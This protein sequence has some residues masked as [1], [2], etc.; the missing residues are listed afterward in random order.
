MIIFLVQ[1][2]IS[3]IWPQQY[4]QNVNPHTL[5]NLP[6][7]QFLPSLTNSLNILV[8][9]VDSNGRN[10]QRFV[11]TRS[12][13]MMLVSIDP[14]KSQVAVIS[15]PRDSRVSIANGHGTDK[16]NAAHALGGPQLAMETVRQTLNV[17]VD[18]YLVMDEEGFR[19]FLEEL[20]PI[21]VLIEKKMN[22]ADHSAALAI[23]LEPGLKSLDARQAEGYIRFR[24]DARG[25]IGR[26]ERQQWFARQIA[27]KFA[28]PQ[29]IIKLPQLL[30]IAS[31][32][33]ITDLSVDEMVKLVG[34]ACHL[35]PQRIEMATLPGKPA[36]IHGISYWLP[37][38]EAAAPLLSK[39]V[40]KDPRP[41]QESDFNMAGGG[42]ALA[43]TPTPLETSVSDSYT[44]IIRYPKGCEKAADDL[45]ILVKQ[46]GLVSKGKYKA[47]LSDCQHE[48]IVE[49]SV[50]ALSLDTLR[51]K[52]PYMSKWPSVIN[53][54]QQ[55]PSDFVFVLTPS[56]QFPA[57]NIA[58][59][60]PQIEQR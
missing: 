3:S 57:T 32:C 31:D 10:T 47:D 8:M 55:A 1:P 23:N 52:F 45:E 37:E 51:T 27:Y 34:F 24:H 28:E 18:R 43:F 41:G 25:D 36:M 21:D 46:A 6:G 38:L 5:V 58:Q 59:I 49:T 26:I 54:D 53:I 15:I 44:A 4:K 39:L 2:I 20:G 30:K 56:S 13:I 19:R 42:S 50:H 7:G 16:I 11:A 29:V 40:N 60:K 22:Y 48:E 35:N 14:Q 9:G 17:P 33:V 12:D